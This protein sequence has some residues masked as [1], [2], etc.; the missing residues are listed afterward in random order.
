MAERFRRWSP[1]PVYVGSNP[2]QRAMKVERRYQYWG[3]EGV[4]WTKWFV[5]KKF[6]TKQEAEDYLKVWKKVKEPN[7]LKG[8][9]RISEC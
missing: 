3:P 8:E 5:V 7:K 4:T 1:K 2:S 6:T 9:Y